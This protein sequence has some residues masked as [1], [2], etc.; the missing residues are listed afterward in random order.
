MSAWW[1]WAGRRPMVARLAAVAAVLVAWEVL[2]RA[3]A[4]PLFM[5]SPSEV[6][7]ALGPL[8]ADVDVLH[9]I[10]TTLWEL[11]IAFAL[12][13]AAGLA[14][15]VPIG[16][17]R[18][19]R[20]SLFPIVMLLYGIPQITILPLVVLA[21]GIGPESRIAF[22]FTHGVFPMIVSIVAGVQNFSPLLATSARSMGATEA[23]VFRH[24]VFL[25]MVPAFFTG[26]RLAMAAVLLGV[27]L[28]ELYSS[29]GGIGQFTTA[30]TQSF[31][32]AN[33]FALIVT[34]AA[35][36]IMMNEAVRR[37]EIRSSRWRG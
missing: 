27:L 36:A 8:Y 3:V 33:L 11:G 32:P 37:A 17:H 10:W 34:L 23:Q 25:Q 20:E 16:L 24:V 2:A 28:A 7:D 35:M 1:R 15:G 6:L 30:Y 21:F 14:I 26:M 22:G 18:A 5:A 12:S 19:S 4:D 13:V 29:Q 9:A 31:Q